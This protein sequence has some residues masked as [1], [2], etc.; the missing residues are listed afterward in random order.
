[1]LGLPTWAGSDL[2]F[3][4]NKSIFPQKGLLWIM[5]SSTG[6]IPVVPLELAFIIKE[7]R[8]RSSLVNVA[9]ARNDLAV[10]KSNYIF[11]FDG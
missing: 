7:R 1:M 3:M 4:C 2:L 6:A 5:E 9:L 8:E 11:Y 10:F